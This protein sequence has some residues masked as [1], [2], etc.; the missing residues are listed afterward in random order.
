V[1]SQLSQAFALI[2]NLTDHLQTLAMKPNTL[3]QARKAAASGTWL[4]QD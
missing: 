1:Y 2:F 4:K 3:Q